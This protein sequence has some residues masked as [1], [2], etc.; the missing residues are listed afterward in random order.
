MDLI[1]RIADVILPV[2]LIVAIGYGYARRRTLD[3]TTFNRIALDV[4]APALVYSALASRDF[5]IGQHLTLLLGGAVII[6]VGGLLAWPLARLC[7]AQ[8]RTLVP[9]VMFNNS[10][11]MGLPLALLAFGP[12]HFGAAVALFAICNL[13]HV[14]VGARITS[15]LARTRDLLLSPVMIGTALGF[16]SALTGLRPP[17][18]A[19]SGLKL[20]G[21][22]MLPM[23]L[24]ALGARLTALTRS[25]LAI[26]LLGAL[27]RPLIGL[28]IAL[29]LAAAL[30]L[31]GAERGQ[32][33]LF[34]ALPPAVMQFMLADR[35]QQE[36]DKVGAMIMLGNALAVVFVPLAL[37]IAL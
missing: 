35:Y 27:A 3:M 23:M 24:F 31:H 10:G 13:L 25:G 14:S 18:V 30:D 34:A 22:A 29:P 2:F 12:A 9:V 15:R 32:L 20:L 6:L 26:G 1:S 36:P 33:L 28:A 8:P 5:V 19:L 11:N 21:D 16:L 17:D 7:G 4:L 37:A